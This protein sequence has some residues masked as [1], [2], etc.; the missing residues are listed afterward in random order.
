MIGFVPT[1]IISRSSTGFGSEATSG[2][3]SGSDR[4]TV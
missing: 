2:V 3:G 4:K 1:K